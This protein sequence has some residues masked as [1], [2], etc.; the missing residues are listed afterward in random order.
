M[1][2]AKPPNAARMHRI[3]VV[4]E[5]VLYSTAAQSE[6]SCELLAFSDI[7]PP[8]KMGEYFSLSMSDFKKKSFHE[9]VDLG[10]HPEK[11]RKLVKLLDVLN[12]NLPPP[13][14]KPCAPVMKPS[15]SA[16]MSLAPKKSTTPYIKKEIY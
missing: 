15:M 16:N 2:Q 1:S 11:A 9:L 6:D 8:T 7:E 13:P 4:G 5:S 10:F 14:P 12:G 3:K